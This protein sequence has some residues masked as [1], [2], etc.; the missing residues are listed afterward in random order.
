MGTNREAEGFSFYTEKDAAL[1]AQEQKKVEYLEERMNY[2]NPAGVLKIYSRAVQERIF[3]TPVGIIYLKKLQQYLKEQPGILPEE[4][5]PIPL[6]VN[7]DGE[8][9]ERTN[10]AKKRI[11]PA[12]KKKSN[13]LP[14]SILLNIGLIIAVIAMFVIT[15]NSSQPNI[16]NYKKNLENQYATWEQELTEREAVVREKELE[17]K[18]QR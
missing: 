8:I 6:F 18:I 17:L 14:I 11:K 1:A 15:L 12:A 13:A 3:Q 2:N 7:F 9:R 16:L 5:P 4:I 10:P